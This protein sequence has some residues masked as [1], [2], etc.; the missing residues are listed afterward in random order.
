MTPKAPPGLDE[1]PEVLDLPNA[2]VEHR[3]DE[4]VEMLPDLSGASRLT[5]HVPPSIYRDVLSIVGA[6]LDIQEPMMLREG[7]LRE[8]APRIDSTPLRRAVAQFVAAI[9][10]YPVVC[11]ELLARLAA[12]G[13]VLDE[14]WAGRDSRPLLLALRDE[15]GRVCA[16]RPDA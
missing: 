15:V 14:G 12:V 1:S 9:P 10:N 7:G 2:A 11:A 16:F 13:R 8:T 6:L 4:I 3:L 5:G